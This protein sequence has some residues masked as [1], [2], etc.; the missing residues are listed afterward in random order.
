MLTDFM[1]REKVLRIGGRRFIVRPPTG[2]TLLMALLRYER[3]IAAMVSG[4]QKYRETDPEA[5]DQLTVSAVAR[6]LASGER[7]AEVLETCCELVG[8][9]PGETREALAHDDAAQRQIAEAAADLLLDPARVG[10]S[11]AAMFSGTATEFDGP[12][13][14][15]V[16]VYLLARAFGVPP[17]TVLD[18]P[19]EQFLAAC[20][21][22]DY[23]Q[24][25]TAQAIERP[26]ARAAS[27]VSGRASADELMAAGWKVSTPQ[28]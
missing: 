21:L 27:T 24:R 17:Q 23:Q 13:D 10:A 26:L 7:G 18:W 22:Y 4:V 16:R 11:I 3:E 5:A 15:E 1:R 19:W 9:L 6:Y 25:M 20:E 12:S 8:A 28:A 14:G 2:R